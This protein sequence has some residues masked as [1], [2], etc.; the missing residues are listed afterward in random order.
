M[1]Q[2]Y[3]PSSDLIDLG[4]IIINDQIEL[5]SSASRIDKPV[6]T[7]DNFLFLIHQCVYKNDVDFMTKVIDI[8]TVYCSFILTQPFSNTLLLEDAYVY[9]LKALATT[10]FNFLN[11]DDD[12]NM[13]KFEKFC[14]IYRKVNELYDIC[15]IYFNLTKHD[16]SKDIYSLY[17]LRSTIATLQDCWDIDNRVYKDMLLR[18]A[19]QQ[20]ILIISDRIKI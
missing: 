1:D 12:N 10:F 11:S 19:I 14:D 3:T 15:S 17:T 13:I 20:S 7:Y 8:S 9:E 4:L 2:T 5:S 6:L 16:P 18:S